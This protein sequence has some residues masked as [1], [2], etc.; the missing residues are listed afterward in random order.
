MLAQQN[1]GSWINTPRLLEEA[2]SASAEG[3]HLDAL[4]LARQAR[5][6]GEAAVRQNEKQQHAIPWQF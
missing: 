4:T 6:E 3:R 5:F 2:K 1:G